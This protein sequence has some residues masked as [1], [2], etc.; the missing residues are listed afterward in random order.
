MMFISKKVRRNMRERRIKKLRSSGGV[1]AV[2][3]EEDDDDDN[4]N[5]HND[6]DNIESEILEVEKKEIDVVKIIEEEKT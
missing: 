5:G 4:N 2:H 1:V 6:N 3:E